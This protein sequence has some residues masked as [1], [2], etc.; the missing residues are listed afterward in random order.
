MR[1]GAL[2]L[3]AGQQESLSTSPALY[4]RPSRAGEIAKLYFYAFGTCS[5]RDIFT[6]LCSEYYYLRAVR[7]RF[8]EQAQHIAQSPVVQPCKAF[9]ENQRRAFLSEKQVYKRKPQA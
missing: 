7:R 6:G 9:V 4:T 3:F 2:A 1:S 8:F 5:Q